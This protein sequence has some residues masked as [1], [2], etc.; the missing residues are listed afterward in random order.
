LNDNLQ[1][2]VISGKRVVFIQK[3]YLL[4]KSWFLVVN[5]FF[6]FCLA[7]LLLSSFAF[8]CLAFVLKTCF[9]FL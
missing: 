7:L 1:V 4:L 6:P 2:F 5:V 3:V 9:V 8:L